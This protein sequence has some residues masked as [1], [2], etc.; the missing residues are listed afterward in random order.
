M[1]KA[2]TEEEKQQIR[3][4]Y[5]R[6]AQQAMNDLRANTEYA[7][8]KAQGSGKSG[9]SD[10]QKAAEAE[11]KARAKEEK[12]AAKAQETAKKKKIKNLKSQ[13]TELNKILK[14]KD[15]TPESRAEFTEILD[16]ILKKLLKLKGVKTK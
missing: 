4:E 14:M 15:L 7:K 12:A 8:P 1:T 11:E 10:E 3:L 6:K 13:V 16:K 2:K 5:S 9:K